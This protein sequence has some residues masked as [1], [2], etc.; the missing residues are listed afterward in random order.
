MFSFKHRFDKKKENE[1]SK[2]KLKFDSLKYFPREISI[3][4]YQEKRTVNYYSLNY[5]TENRENKEKIFSSNLVEKR[6]LIIGIF[7]I[8]F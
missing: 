5:F 3:D 7:L 6:L 2:T 1:R 4:Q 8:E